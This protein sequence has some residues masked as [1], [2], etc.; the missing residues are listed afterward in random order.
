MVTLNK[1]LK[2]PM[3][4][5][6][7]SSIHVRPSRPLKKVSES[8][9]FS[10]SVNLFVGYSSIAFPFKYKT[11]DRFILLSDDE[12]P[13]QAQNACKDSQQLPPSLKTVSNHLE[14]SH[15]R[16]RGSRKTRSTTKNSINLRPPL[17]FDP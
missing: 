6:S 8:N 1:I 4:K 12:K 14:L 3:W 2:V 10:C 13:Y 17:K 16:R 11:S 15:Y 5:P 9:P 7:G